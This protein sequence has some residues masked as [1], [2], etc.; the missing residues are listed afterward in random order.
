[1]CYRNGAR[2]H[3]TWY[4]LAPV[5]RI[6]C[7]TEHFITHLHCG[8]IF[9]LKVRTHGHISPAVWI[10][11]CFTLTMLTNGCIC[12]QRSSQ[13]DLF[14]FYGILDP[15]SSGISLQVLNFILQQNADVHGSPIVFAGISFSTLSSMTF[16]SL[17]I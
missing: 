15:S 11:G 5:D 8:S 7:K 9:K 16:Q 14:H 17:F 3:G 1:M 10:L 13:D 4:H 12:D 6:K 2:L